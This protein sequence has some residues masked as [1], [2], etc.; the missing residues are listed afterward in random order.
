MVPV[1]MKWWNNKNSKWDSYF[2]WSGIPCYKSTLD[3]IT[4]VNV[5]VRAASCGTLDKI[6]REL[7]K[8]GLIFRVL[9]AQ[10]FRKNG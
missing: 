8:L 1:V 2:M 3:R 9:N 4:F 10:N 5:E 7:T 6:S